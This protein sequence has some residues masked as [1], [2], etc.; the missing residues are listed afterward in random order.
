[1]TA[2]DSGLGRAGA[3]ADPLGLYPF[4]GSG[5]PGGLDAV[6]AE[7]RRSTAEK[8]E[9]IV[10]LRR[11]LLAECGDALAA[12]AAAMAERFAAGGRLFTFGN[13]GSST[14]AA[15]LATAFLRPVRGPS[16]PALCLTGDSA[17]LTALSNDVSFEVVF[18]RQLAALGRPGDIALGLSTSGGSPNVASAVRAAAEGGMLTVA[19]A[20]YSGGRLGELDVLDH[21]FAVPSASVHRIQEAQTTLYHV[22]WELVTRALEETSGPGAGTAAGTERPR[23]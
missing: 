8:A 10:G 13:G 4:L 7:V 19:M 20:G 22:L 5:A 3:A 17:V 14:D 23:R 12:C 1:M 2:S 9:E 11:L 18:A 21:L 15:G 6:T 16:L